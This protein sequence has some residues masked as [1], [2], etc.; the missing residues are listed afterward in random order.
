MGLFAKKKNFFQSSVFFGCVLNGKIQQ[1]NDANV[2]KGLFI[3]TDMLIINNNFHC[4]HHMKLSREEKS[5][6]SK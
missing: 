2:L 5:T 4:L 6:S 3:D 1:I